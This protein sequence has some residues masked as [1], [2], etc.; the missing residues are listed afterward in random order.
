MEDRTNLKF[1]ADLA[2]FALTIDK[3][4]EAVVKKVA[5]DIFKD[6][7]VASPVDSG[8][9]RASHQIAMN[10]PSEEVVEVP[11]GQKLSKAESK[12]KAMEQAKNLS[13]FNTTDTIWISNNLPYAEKIEYGGYND[14]PKVTG[15]YPSQMKNGPAGV[16]RL[17]IQK[18]E[19]RLVKALKEIK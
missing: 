13:Q 16:Y 6:I 17:A 2:K 8:A 3:S 10:T 11:K 7:I 19:K 18:A 14:G 4:T 12:K 1:F 5:L 9:Y 15:G